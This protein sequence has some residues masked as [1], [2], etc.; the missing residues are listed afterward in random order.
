MAQEK[1]FSE[2]KQIQERWKR[3][4]NIIKPM[5]VMFQP[6]PKE[7]IGHIITFYPRSWLGVNKYFRAL[8]LQVLSLEVKHEVLIHCCKRGYMELLKKMLV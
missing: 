7:V 6:V 4:N 2:V 1:D 8:S 5:E 3:K